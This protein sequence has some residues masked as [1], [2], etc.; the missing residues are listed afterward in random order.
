MTTHIQ[1]PDSTTRFVEVLKD[2]LS[3]AYEA[4]AGDGIKQAAIVAAWDE[5]RGVM[6]ENRQ[7]EAIINSLSAGLEKVVNQRDAAIRG[8]ERE[9]EAHNH[10]LITERKYSIEKALRRLSG[11]IAI[12]TDSHILMPEA[13]MVLETLAGLRLTGAEAELAQVYEAMHVLAEALGIENV[14]DREGDDE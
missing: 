14:L 6:R 12:D 2:A 1:K 13:R 5:I 3:V 8:A 7:R 11:Q 9:R 4:A 10:E